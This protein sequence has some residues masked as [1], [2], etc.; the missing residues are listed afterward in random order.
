MTG[1]ISE[2]CQHSQRRDDPVEGYDEIPTPWTVADEVGWS[3]IDA[4]AC[5]LAEE[6]GIH[7]H[8]LPVTQADLI[9]DMLA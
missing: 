8:G 6:F 5:A 9:R 7:E 2:L 1:D 3:K 4:I